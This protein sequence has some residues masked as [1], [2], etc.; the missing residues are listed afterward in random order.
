MQMALSRL[1]VEHT[2]GTCG[3]ELNVRPCLPFRAATLVLAPLLLDVSLLPAQAIP[4]KSMLGAAHTIRPVRRAP[5]LPAPSGIGPEWEVANCSLKGPTS[6]CSAFCS[7]ISSSYR[8]LPNGLSS[9]SAAALPSE[10]AAS[11]M[12]QRKQAPNIALGPLENAQRVVIWIHTR[13]RMLTGEKELQEAK[14]IFGLPELRDSQHFAITS[15]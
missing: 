7:I 9:A 2:L 13:C 14:A 1:A 6:S 11:A 15:F 8:M 3:G 12:F 5:F 4:F 10:R